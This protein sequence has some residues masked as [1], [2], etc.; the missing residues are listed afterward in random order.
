MVYDA[1]YFFKKFSKI[2]PNK[3]TTGRISNGKGQRCVL[4]HCGVK[5]N[6]D[7]VSYKYSA[8]GNALNVIFKE[9]TG[10]CAIDVNDGYI[11]PRPGPMKCE[12][13]PVTITGKTPR[14]RVL[15]ALKKIVAMTN[16]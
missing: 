5:D 1:K 2:P 8:Q 11:T 6:G 10:F 13:F 7:K 3:W 16:K 12:G 15:D 9:F 4:G 14:A